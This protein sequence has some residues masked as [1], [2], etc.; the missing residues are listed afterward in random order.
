[1]KTS[2]ILT[3]LFALVLS[4][5]CGQTVAEAQRK[6]TVKYPELAREGSP[7]HNKFIVLYKQAKEKDPAFLTQPNWPLLLADRAAAEIAPQVDPNP[8]ELTKAPQAP[9]PAK[10]V[11]TGFLDVPWG[12]TPDKAKEII[13]QRQ[14]VVFNAEES[15]EHNLIFA[16]G[17]FADFPVEMLALQFVDRQFYHGVVNIKPNLPLKTAWEDLV[18]GLTKKYGEGKVISNASKDH[19]FASW[20]FPDPKSPEVKITCIL[21]NGLVGL[22][23]ANL[24][25]QIKAEAERKSRIK[26]KDF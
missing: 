20:A 26:T 7:L 6:A 22:S 21:G 14:S 19:L 2:H 9:Q 17:T 8:T 23:Y 25:L 10:Q 15:D 12:T 1:M 16:G 18:S 3:T 4:K 5:A 11:V 13:S 24:P